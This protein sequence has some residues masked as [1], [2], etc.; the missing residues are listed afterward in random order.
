MDIVPHPRWRPCFFKTTPD[1][2]PLRPTCDRGIRL[3]LHIFTRRW[4]I[5]DF[6]RLFSLDVVSGPARSHVLWWGQYLLRHTFE[7]Y[8]IAFSVGL[9]VFGCF[10]DLFMFVLHSPLPWSLLTLVGWV[11]V[12]LNVRAV[13]SIPQR[14][15][16][17]CIVCLRC[18]RTAG[19]IRLRR[20]QGQCTLQSASKDLSLVSV[21]QFSNSTHT[22]VSATRRWRVLPIL[23]EC[24]VKEGSRWL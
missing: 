19:F 22:C 14:V 20:R 15:V 17:C 24:T 18:R 11:A 5:T 6:I 21:R 1:W 7:C 10:Q 4:S 23:V 13:V 12:F 16:L 8:C 2:Y 3:A 9:S